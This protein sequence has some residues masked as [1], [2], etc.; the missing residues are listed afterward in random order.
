MRL[1]ELNHKSYEVTVAPEGLTLTPFKKIVRRDK[2]KA[3]TKAQAEL[4]FVYFFADLKSDFQTT[5]H[6]R[7]R[8]AEITEVL[9][10][11]KGWLPDKVVMEAVKFYRKRSKTISSQLLEDSRTGASKV[12]KFLKDV[13]L[14]LVDNNNKPIYDA[15]KVA[16]TI[17][18]LPA[19]IEAID[20]IEKI[21]TSQQELNKSNHRG[22]QEK[23]M[24][25]DEMTK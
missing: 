17:K 7:E 15:K 14:A 3:K 8:I 6:E 11:P 21:V 5:L 2:T 25:E 13:D 4:A 19:I 9:E 12:S 18:A 23:G 24:F 20:D 1:F 16:E 22:S 10:L